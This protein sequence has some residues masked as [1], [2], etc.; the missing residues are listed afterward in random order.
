MVYKSPDEYAP[1]PKHFDIFEQTGR[2]GD[3]KETYK[4]E[5]WST[6]EYEIPVTTVKAFWKSRIKCEL[7]KPGNLL[8]FCNIIV[9]TKG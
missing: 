5:R 1:W 7:T 8:L 2:K 4:S 3:V 6:L 9:H